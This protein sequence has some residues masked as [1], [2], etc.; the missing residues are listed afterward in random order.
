MV[1]WLVTKEI[2]K[3]HMIIVTRNIFLPI[4]SKNIL[5]PQMLVIKRHIILNMLQTGSMNLFVC[6]VFFQYL[7]SDW[8]IARPYLSLLR[9]KVYKCKLPMPVFL[10]P[11]IFYKLIFHKLCTAFQHWTYMFVTDDLGSGKQF[12]YPACLTCMPRSA[13]TQ[14]SDASQI[15]VRSWPPSRARTTRP[16]ARDIS[17]WVRKLKPEVH[18]GTRTKYE[19]H[20]KSKIKLGWQVQLQYRHHIL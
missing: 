7:S 14:A 12:H 16:P 6:L 13:L 3:I 15:A 18:K 8:W 9:R 2:W 17:W 10:S 20:A 1:Q 5:N 4:L 11:P 19:Y